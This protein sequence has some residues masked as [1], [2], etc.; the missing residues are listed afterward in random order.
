MIAPE[1]IS[2]LQETE[3]LKHD[4]VSRNFALALQKARND[5]GFTQKDFATKVK[6][7]LG[8]FGISVV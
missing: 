1:L 4:H 5:K 6:A 7:E 8:L 2:G 3:E